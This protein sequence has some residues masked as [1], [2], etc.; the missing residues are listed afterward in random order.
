[1]NA[2]LVVLYLCASADRCD[3]KVPEFRYYDKE[4]ACQ[5]AADDYQEK[6]RAKYPQLVDVIYTK[7]EL[8]PR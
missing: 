7:C 6:M 8:A 4:T 1:M 2:W 3:R 5:K